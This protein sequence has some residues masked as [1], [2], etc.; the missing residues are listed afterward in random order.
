MSALQ[1]I[2]VVEDNDG[3]YDTVVEAMRRSGLPHQLQRATCGDECLDMLHQLVRLRSALPVL[4]LL[5]LNTPGSDGRDALGLIKT[6][7]KLRTIPTVILSTSSNPRDVDFCY[8]SH[9]NAYHT[10]PVSHRAHLK[11]LQDIFGYWLG[12]ALL[13]TETPLIKNE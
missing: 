4:V 10:K 13:S 12:C 5:D 6:C 9:A 11:T 2:L 7:R 8:A 1:N 3:D